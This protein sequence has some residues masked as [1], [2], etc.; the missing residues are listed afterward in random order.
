MSTRWYIAPAEI[1]SRPNQ[2]PPEELATKLKLLAKGP[3][4]TYEQYNTINPD[5]TPFH[6][7]MLVRIEAPNHAKFAG[8]PG[9]VYFPDFGGLDNDPQTVD[10]SVWGPFKNDMSSKVGLGINPNNRANIR[11]VLQDILDVIQPGNQ[12]IV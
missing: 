12:R 1:I 9:V 5:G 8:Q 3:N 10:S 7:H 11:E 6:T 2:D 4:V